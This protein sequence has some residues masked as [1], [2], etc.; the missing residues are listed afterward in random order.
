MLS[1]H[2]VKETS[3]KPMESVEGIIASAVELDSTKAKY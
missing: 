3:L 2:Q 1:W